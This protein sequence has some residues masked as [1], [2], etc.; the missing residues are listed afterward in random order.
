[1][2]RSSPNLLEMD[3]AHTSGTFDFKSRLPRAANPY[4]PGFRPIDSGNLLGW[5]W[6]LGWREGEWLRVRKVGAK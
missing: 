2:A 5:A 1:M 3:V 4:S 6:D